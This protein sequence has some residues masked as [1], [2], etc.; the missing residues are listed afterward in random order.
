[1]KAVEHL[2]CEAHTAS[3]SCWLPPDIQTAITFLTTRV[4]APD[5]DDYKKPTWVMKYLQVDNVS[6][7]MT[8]LMTGHFP[9]SALSLMLPSLP[10]TKQW[11]LNPKLLYEPCKWLQ[12]GISLWY[13]A[14]YILQYRMRGAESRSVL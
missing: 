4:K 7:R 11:I 3:S 12:C 8:S 9:E 6:G 10:I 1:M 2:E 5:N 14:L 13:I